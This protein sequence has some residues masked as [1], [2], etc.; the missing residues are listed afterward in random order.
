MPRQ[1]TTPRALK[2]VLCVVLGALALAAVALA[3]LAC[4]ER[5]NSFTA[6]D[7]TAYLQ[8]GTTLEAAAASVLPTKQDLDA[9]EVAFY[10]YDYDHGIL[11][12]GDSMLRLSV[13]YETDAFDSARQALDER[14][15]GLDDAWRESF[16][17][18]GA[19]YHCYV[20]YGEASNVAYA[21]AYSVD[22]EQRKISYLLYESFDLTVMSAHSALLL[23]Y[24]EERVTPA[25]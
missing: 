15:L 10:E 11:L 13:V 5:V 7:L 22:E 9:Q 21:M 14:Y 18:D 19:L 17:F 4:Y 1:T 3:S 23:A 25:P 16:C 8:N 24:G 12:P 6:T 20:F 2:I